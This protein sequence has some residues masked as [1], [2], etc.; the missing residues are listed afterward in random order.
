MGTYKDR[1]PVIRDAYGI[2]KLTPTDCLALQG[3]P[4]S[5][6]FPDIPVNEIYKQL[7]NTVCVPVIE[8]IAK[9]IFDITGS[10]FF[11]RSMEFA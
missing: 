3:F 5:Y 10:E 7:G 2:R 9:R 11:Q 8:R 1:I 6:R 4:I